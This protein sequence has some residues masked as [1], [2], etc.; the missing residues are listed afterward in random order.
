MLQHWV[1]Q[2]EKGMSHGVN[3]KDNGLMMYKTFYTAKL[4]TSE[5]SPARALA[6]VCACVG[7]LFEKCKRGSNTSN[8]MSDW[9]VQLQVMI[10]YWPLHSPWLSWTW[11]VL[12]SCRQCIKIIVF[13]ITSL[14]CRGKASK[15]QCESVYLQPHAKLAK[16]SEGVMILT[17]I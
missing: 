7:H 13:Q 15:R 6:A 12:K 3:L 5:S 9:G 11:P 4:K 17:M 2:K 8:G 10:L 14:C 1:C 16:H